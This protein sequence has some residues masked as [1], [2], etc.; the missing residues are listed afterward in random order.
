MFFFFFFGV[1][2][3]TFMQMIAEHAENEPKSL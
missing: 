1:A 2:K 3:S